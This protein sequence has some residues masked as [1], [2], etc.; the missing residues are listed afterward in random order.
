MTNYW[1]DEKS[2]SMVHF[3]VCGETPKRARVSSS[4]AGIQKLGKKIYGGGKSE[5]I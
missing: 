1:D 5:K 2:R 3:W 4:V